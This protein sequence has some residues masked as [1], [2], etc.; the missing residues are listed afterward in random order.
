MTIKSLIFLLFISS[1]CISYPPTF[2]DE[3]PCK[4]STE[5]SYETKL[6]Q[7]I[8]HFY[9]S[10]KSIIKNLQNNLYFI[11]QIIIDQFL[12]ADTHKDELATVRFSEEDEIC[13]AENNF[14]ANRSPV[15]QEAVERLTHKKLPDGKVPKIGLCFSG[16]GF[17]AMI[18]TLGFLQAA[19]EI[20]LLDATMYMT[21]LSGSTWA[22]APWIASKK[23]L[24]TYINEL[25]SKISSGLD[26]IDDPNELAHLM[27]IILSKLLTNQFISAMDIYGAV[28]ANTLLK[29]LGS[30]RFHAT[31]S[32]THEYLNN[33]ELPLPIYTAV[34]TM[35]GPYE[36]MEFT[37]YEVGNLSCKSYIPLWSYGRKF[38]ECQSANIKYEQTLGYYMGIFGSAFEVNIEDILHRTTYNMTTILS[39]LPSFL[40]EPVEDTI[41]LLLDSPVGSLRLF[42][43]ILPN[44]TFG[45]SQDTLFKDVKKLCLI[46]AGIDYNLPLPPLLRAARNLDIIVIYDGSSTINGAHELR[47]AEKYAREHN[48]KF[49]EINFSEIL[50][51]PV[52]VFQDE[53][54][55]S[56]PIIVYFQRVTNHQYSSSF[57]PDLCVEEGYCNTFNFVYSHA[58]I[59][60]LSGLANFTLTE[61]QEVIASVLA[62]VIEKKYSA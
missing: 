43:S 8:D 45:C 14:I 41:K 58:N 21:G 13:R 50:E 10:L 57:N 25:S 53:N 24:S 35:E 37:P 22:I 52:S 60:E 46:D 3:Y 42:P 51:N 15:I 9:G 6:P 59:A 30:R 4:S 20:G 16:G 12:P 28:L 7:A 62:D 11:P 44:F 36:W 40:Q 19:Q 38:R 5:S 29:D 34:A 18:L 56:V 27:R 39:Y 26:H 61:H 54:D 1:T 55:P 49:P 31:M 17:R 32:E 33:G 47:L 2:L 23:D 48:L